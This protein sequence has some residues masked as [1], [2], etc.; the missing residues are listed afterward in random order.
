MDQFNF[1]LWYETYDP[2]FIEISQKSFIPERWLSYQ[3]IDHDIFE[4]KVIK[5][6][7]KYVESLY[8][9]PELV[10]ITG[11]TVRLRQRNHAEIL[12]LD[13]DPSRENTFR[14]LDRPHMRQYYQTKQQYPEDHECF[15][16]PYI[17]YAPWF[18]DADASVLFTQSEELSPFKVY[19]TCYS[20]K[21][22]PRDSRYAEP[23]FIPFKFKK[24]G[25]H[26]INDNRGKIKRQSP[27]FDMVFDLND[28]LI[29]N[30]KDFYEK[31]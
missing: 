18:L 25:P 7:N 27:M 9:R 6:I 19:D 28:I 24:V 8:P 12:L 29:K 30:I 23:A 10:S 31:N 14:N 5:P 2:N 4:G 17:F 21:A 15:D 13:K 20:Y 3:A 26:M 16:Q 22:I 11:N 1:N